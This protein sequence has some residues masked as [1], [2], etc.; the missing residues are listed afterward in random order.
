[1]GFDAVTV[2]PITLMELHSINNYGKQVPSSEKDFAGIKKTY[3]DAQVF[4]YKRLY[5][6][7]RKKH[8]EC[9]KQI[10]ELYKKFSN[11][12]DKQ[13]TSLLSECSEKM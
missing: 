2:L 10:F 7:S 11:M 5:L 3:M 4:W 8:L 13:A 12:Y 9:R 6:Q 1:M